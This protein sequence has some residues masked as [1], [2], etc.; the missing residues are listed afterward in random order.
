MMI[1]AI[2]INDWESH[3]HSLLNLSETVTV[4]LGQS[5]NGKSSIV[6]AF[7]WVQNNRPVSTVY[8]PRGNKKPNTIVSISKDDSF[9]SR[10]RTK[11]KN[12]YETEDGEF[13][14]LR[15]GVPVQVTDFL[16]MTEINLQLQK[17]VHYMLTDTPG[18]RAKRLNDIAG[19]SEMDVAI[20][21]VNKLHRA[22]NSEYQSKTEI[23]NELEGEYKELDWVIEA[24][25]EYADLL[26]LES[27]RN[28]LQD[29][30][31][32]IQE[33]LIKVYNTETQL[34]KLPDISALKKIADIFFIDDKLYDLEEK[35]ANIK[36]R[37]KAMLE[38]E[39]Q[40]SKGN[41]PTDKELLILDTKLAEI[42]RKE[43]QVK[44]IKRAIT[45]IHAYE[46]N[47]LLSGGS[48]L[49]IEG[50]EKEFMDKF[51]VCPFCNQSMGE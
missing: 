37:L 49:Y 5:H 41:L 13:K 16:G 19:L 30:L 29:K 44:T 18:V 46:N 14:A 8:F 21:S 42:D 47:L 51:D 31:K 35:E 32:Y 6:R 48:I 28:V 24:Q 17:D 50:E 2:E 15:S 39:V 26:K 4:I 22:V 40:L 38:I 34:M 7:D 43:R 9:I 1:D 20:D 36:K 3:K 25:K 45:S 12:Y 11:S 23:L 27:K 10:I 33:C